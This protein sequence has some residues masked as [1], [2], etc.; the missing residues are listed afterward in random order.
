MS[1]SAMSSTSGGASF[2]VNL[3]LIFSFIS[4]YFA[5]S[6]LINANSYWLIPPSSIAFE[7]WL[8][9]LLSLLSAKT[10]IPSSTNPTGNA[11]T[12]ARLAIPTVPAAMPPHSAYFIKCCYTFSHVHFSLLKFVFVYR[13]F[14]VI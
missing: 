9:M 10:L 8:S 6:S 3:V 1:L 14:F 4:E 13:R 12:L 2:G 7:T 11:T 5:L